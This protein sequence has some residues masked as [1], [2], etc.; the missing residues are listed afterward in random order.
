M[1]REHLLRMPHEKEPIM[2]NKSLFKTIAGKFLPKTNTLNSHAAPAYQL[3]DK[4]ALAQLAATGCM[5]GTFYAGGEEQLTKVL[6]LAQKVEPEFVAKVALYARSKGY[7]KDMPA[8]LCAVLSVLSPGLMAEI[9]DRVIDSPKMLRNF[10]QIMRSG[11]VGRKSLGTLPK[12]LVRAW[13]EKRT[14]EQLFLGSVGNDPSLADIIKMVHPKPATKRREALY[15]YLIGRDHN[16]AELPEKV[17][18][19]E[20]FK[21]GESKIVPDVPFQ[22]LTALPLTKADWTRIADHGTWQMTRMNLNTFARHGVFEDRGIVRTVAKRLADRELIKK[23]R[24]FPY[25]LMVAYMNAG[26]SVPGEIKEALQDAMEIACENIPE[27]DAKV[28]VFVDISGSMH[29]PITGYRK[30]ST[31]AVR[32]VDVAALVAAAIVRRNP[33]TEVLPFESRAIT[34]FRFNPRDAVMTNARKFSSL[35]A[36]GTNCSAPLAAL[37]AR[38]AEGDLVVYVSDNESWVD[39]PH[40]G[41]YGGS[42]TQTL[43]EWA[44]FKRRNPGAKMVCID[45]VAN[46][47]TQ[48]AERPGEILNIGGFSDSVFEVI[49]RFADGTLDPNHWVSVIERERI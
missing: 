3:T 1:S 38:K 32:C 16:V 21:R 41:S 31:T 11:Q 42:R 43:N 37:N 36:G 48:A 46:T 22:M 12:R 23:A 34:E 18:A 4:H 44:M 19:F 9:F 30:G 35:P 15:G 17:L 47:H 27:V 8:L 28:H 25:Q 13:L 10:V 14:E 33:R 7:M 26:P 40:Y 24:A 6:D 5:S 29:S 2:A 45:L 49:A 39:A 20:A